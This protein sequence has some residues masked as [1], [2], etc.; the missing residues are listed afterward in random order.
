MEQGYS[1]NKICPRDYRIILYANISKTV[2][3]RTF[4][5]EIWNPGEIE[6]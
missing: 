5:L 1:L 4:I 2:I 3:A 6:T